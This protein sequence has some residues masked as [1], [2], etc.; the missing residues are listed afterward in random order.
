M[1][2][3]AIGK[4]KLGETLFAM[5]VDMLPDYFYV[6]DS[7]MRVVYVN[8]TAADYFGLPKE[9]IIGRKFEELGSDREYAH[10]FIELGRQIMATGE[11]RVSDMDPFNEPDGT[12]SYYRR[13]DIPFRHPVT[14][15]LMLMGLAQEIT[16][17]VE[18]EKQERRIAI[19]GREMQ[20]AQEIQR[21]LLPKELRIDWIDLSGFSVPAAYAGGDFYDWLRA[22]DGSVVLGL[23]DVS[24]H[25][26]GPALVAAECRAYWRGMAQSLPLRDAVVRLNEL[27]LDDLSGDRFVTL[28]T[29][30]LSPDGTLEV[31]S[32]AHGPLV[33]CRTGG[34]VELLDSHTFPL[35][36]T[37][38]LAGEEVTVRRLAPGDTLLMFSDGVTET[39]NREGQ[40]WH[41]DGLLAGLARHRGTCGNGLLRAI[42]HENLVFADGEPQGDDRSVVVA[43]FRGH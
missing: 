2:D 24:G 35:G 12:L 32:A 16:D 20:I 23:G 34:A 42:D 37:S 22:L 7:D 4:G 5:L 17:R 9:E 1:G 14:G 19:M 27:I 30:K 10:R 33:L 29:A 25:G 40:Q 28:A 18:R 3:K 26:V 31:Y 38:E 6:S 11:P 43:T 41:T 39:R 8:K 13:Y 36:V 21:S 15:E